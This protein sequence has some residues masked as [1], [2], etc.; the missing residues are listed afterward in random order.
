MI[1]SFTLPA[2][3]DTSGAALLVETLLSRRGRGL[4]L[5][6]SRVEVLGAR[7]IEVI[8]AAGRQWIEDGVPL[9]VVAMSER[10]A[11]TCAVL[12]LSADTPWTGPGNAKGSLA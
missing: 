2:R 6:A 7:A 10:Y 8:I 5:D 1:E 11:A 4:E 3:L 9:S 12:G